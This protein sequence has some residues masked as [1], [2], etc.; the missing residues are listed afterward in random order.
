M[1]CPCSSGRS[2]THDILGALK[3]LKRNTWSWEVKMIVG[4]WKGLKGREQEIDLSRHILM[5]EILKQYI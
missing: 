4:I 1:G 3:G 5:Y 2:Y